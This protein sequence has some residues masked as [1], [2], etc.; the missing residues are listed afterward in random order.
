MIFCERIIIEDFCSH[1]VTPLQIFEGIVVC[2]G[3]HMQHLEGTLKDH[4][5]NSTH[6][7]G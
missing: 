5:T 3:E 6:R 7:F 2:R 4:L 1:M